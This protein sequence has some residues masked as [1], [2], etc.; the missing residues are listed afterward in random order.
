[1]LCRVF[2]VR[3]GSGSLNDSVQW[4]EKDIQQADHIWWWLLYDKAGVDIGNTG[5]VSS[6]YNFYRSHDWTWDVK[7][8]EYTGYIRHMTGKLFFS[9]RESLGLKYPGGA[10]AKSEEAWAGN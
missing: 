10:A 9:S 1:M 7:E 8:V 5:K 6:G 2:G 3:W 4:F